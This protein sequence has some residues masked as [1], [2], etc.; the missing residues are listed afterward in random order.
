MQAI[1]NDIDW[2]PN[3]IGELIKYNQTNKQGYE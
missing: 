1:H 2:H 3:M